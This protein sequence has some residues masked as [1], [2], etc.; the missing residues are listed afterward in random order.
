MVMNQEQHTPEHVAIRKKRIA[1]TASRT[2]AH[3]YA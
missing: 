1:S 3:T 2:H